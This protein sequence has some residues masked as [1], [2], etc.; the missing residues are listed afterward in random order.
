MLMAKRNAREVILGIRGVNG[1]YVKV[2]V[3]GCNNSPLLGGITHGVI[4]ERILLFKT[5][6]KTMR[7]GKGLWLAKN[8]CPGIALF[9]R[10]V[11][12][13]F[14]LR[15]IDFGLALD[16]L[17]FLETENLGLFLLYKRYENIL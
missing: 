9:L 15:K 11:P 7:Y 6:G 14:I 3:F 4:N 10:R 16:C 2:I 12:A 13:F 1:D 17:G 8:S 5:F